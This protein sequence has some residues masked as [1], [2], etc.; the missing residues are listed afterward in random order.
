MA[1]PTA[2]LSIA[3]SDPS[4]G[5]GI[6][7]DLK[8]FAALKIYGC[9][10]ITCLTAQ[11]SQGVNSTQAVSGAFIKK[12]IELILADLPISHIKI[13]MV[14]SS[15]AALAISECLT[16]FKGQIILDPVLKASDGSTLTSTDSLPHLKTVVSIASVITPNIPELAALTNHSCANE[17]E[18]Y[19]QASL[20]LKTYPKLRAVIV[21][22][23]HYQESN[24]II[25]DFLIIKPSLGGLPTIKKINHPRII[26]AN[27]HGTGCAFS[28][29]LTA[30]HLKQNSYSMAFDSAVHFMDK[31]LQISSAYKGGMQHHLVS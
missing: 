20:L 17:K 1:S 10:A 9:A 5:A 11:N 23:G 8:T 22:G 24:E 7:A 28:S 26:T 6:Q 29:A 18:I 27:T 14:G 2:C 25:T 12:Q 3:G 30:Y 15:E 19:Q 13:G 21:T 31:L 16:N 4:G